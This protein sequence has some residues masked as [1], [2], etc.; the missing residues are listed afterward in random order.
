MFRPFIST[1][2][3][4][5]RLKARSQLF[6]NF[7]YERRA[8]NSIPTKQ[9]HSRPNLIGENTCILQC[10]AMYRTYI[11]AVPSTHSLC[12][13]CGKQHFISRSVVGSSVSVLENDVVIALPTC[14][15]YYTLWHNMYLQTCVC[16][17]LQHDCFPQTSGA[18]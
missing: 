1:A 10:E 12:V 2:Q 13:I 7:F 16:K 6:G 14:I 3:H 17:C 8:A 9:K 15:V 11:N 18:R 4:R 5:M